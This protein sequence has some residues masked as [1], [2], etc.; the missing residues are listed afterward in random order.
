[1]NNCLFIKHFFKVACTLRQ[2]WQSRN[3]KNRPNK[4]N[5]VITDLGGG[6]NFPMFLF[7]PLFYVTALRFSR[8]LPC[9]L[10]A[11]RGRITRNPEHG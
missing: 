2:K 4:N 8:G 7:A 10:T 9:A 5:D 3:N 6:G 1:M 11:A